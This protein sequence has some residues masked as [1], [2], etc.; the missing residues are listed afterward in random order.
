MHKSNIQTFSSISLIFIFLLMIYA[1][2]IKTLFTPKA[3]LT[4]IEKRTPAAM[5]E[6]RFDK[7]AIEAFP[8]RF[9]EYYN[10]HFGFRDSLIH[11][12]NYIKTKWLA[13]SPVPKVMIGR[14]DW[15]FYKHAPDKIMEDLHG[16]NPFTHSELKA[17]RLNLENKRDWLAG[18]DIHYLFVAAPNKHS[19]YPEY[20]PAARLKKK[21]VTRLD[22][23]V[24][25]LNEHSD[26]QI[27]DLRDVLRK[28]KIHNRLYF[29]TD[30]HWNDL[31]AFVAYKSIMGRISQWFPQEKVLDYECFD[32]SVKHSTDGELAIMLGLPDS[33]P[34]DRLLL[35]LRSPC[36]KKQDL[37]LALE[38][39]NV[40]EKFL[41]RCEKASLCAVV[42]RDSFFTRIVPF[43]S[44]HFGRISYIWGYYDQAIYNHAIMKELI[45]QD[46]P[47][48]VIEEQ[49]ERLLA[50]PASL[51][52]ELADDL[53]RNRFN[54][55]INTVLLVN[56]DKGYDG[57]HS[58][59]QMSV[60]SD[61]R[62]LILRST[63][64][65]SYF[66]LPLLGLSP[67]AAL[68]IRVVI[69]SPKDTD[70]QLYYCSESVPFHTEEQSIHRAIRKGF[71]EVFFQP[72]GKDLCGHLRLDIGRTSGEFLL[73]TIE[74]RGLKD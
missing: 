31:G 41:M 25:Y 18:Q 62:G 10:D 2:P 60:L 63:G 17:F 24:G 69:T 5:P 61:P 30:T 19:I 26:I 64:N 49:G 29:P 55:S 73:H 70:L 32:E 9:E 43:L 11:W 21:G 42:F 40:R 45:R 67:T 6:L 65:D 72:P 46:R 38:S 59:H 7:E 3:D 51:D 13:K 57:I 34:G 22:Q 15:L 48:I 66:S 71:N 37:D 53:Q 58:L 50:Y 14:D 20:I 56:R 28:A 33:F 35:K 68:V 54:G 12:H 39:V 52:E 44:E 16:E 27:L 23:L 4:K 36:S 1:P 8:S 47:D 74:V